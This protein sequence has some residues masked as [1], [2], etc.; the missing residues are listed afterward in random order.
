M[1]T[2]TCKPLRFG[3]QIA[4][5]AA[6]LMGLLAIAPVAVT[7]GTQPAPAPETRV[8]KVSVVDLD[9]STPEG[10]RAARD[11]LHAMALRLCTQLEDLRDL[12][13]QS[14]FVAC[15]DDTLAGALRQINTSAL[16]AVTRVAKVSLADL[17]LSTPEGMRAARDRLHTMARRLCADLAH[18]RDLS[19]QPNFVVCVD[20]TLAGGLR[21]VN[22]LAA[23][24]KSRT[25]RRITP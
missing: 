25:A 18:N 21:Q 17:D 9:L 7:A 24:E 8:A 23:A 4:V 2:Y 22:A 1:N 12:S 20:D 5:R 15:V 13:H 10:M 6:A 16:A 3:P 14:N 11:R 19:Y